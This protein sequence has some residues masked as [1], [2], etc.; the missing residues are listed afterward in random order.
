MNEIVRRIPAAERHRFTV[1]DVLRMQKLASFPMVR[2]S[3]FSRES[4]FACRLKTM[5]MSASRV[6]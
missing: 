4:L 1:D 5:R 2:A 6:N 3:S